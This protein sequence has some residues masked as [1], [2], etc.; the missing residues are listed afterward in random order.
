MTSEIQ[1]LKDKILLL[2]RQNLVDPNQNRKKTALINPWIHGDY[3][4]EDA[5]L[6]RVAVTEQASIYGS[7]G[8]G[9]ANQ[10]QEA[11]IRINIITKQGKK[12]EI[13]GSKKDAE[14]LHAI[15]SKV[16]NTLE[17]TSRYSIWAGIGWTIPVAQGSNIA[18]GAGREERIQLVLDYRFTRYSTS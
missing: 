2:L 4:R 14:L 15:E 16:R 5:G 13:Y 9:A 8:I 1:V 6:P 3:P 10:L 7:A 17:A 18:R 12:Y 11:H